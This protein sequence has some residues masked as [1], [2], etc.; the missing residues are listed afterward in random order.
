MQNDS[1]PPKPKHTA[2]FSRDK[3]TEI[4]LHDKTSSAADQ[5]GK[6]PI[7]N[8]ESQTSSTPRSIV[9]AAQHEKP[10]KPRNQAKC[11][12]GLDSKQSRWKNIKKMLLF[13]PRQR[14]RNRRARAEASKSQAVDKAQSGA[15]QPKIHSSSSNQAVPM[16]EKSMKETTKPQESKKQETSDCHFIEQTSPSQKIGPSS[17]FVGVA[18][19]KKVVSN[20]GT[21]PLRRNKA[22]QI[23]PNV[24]KG[25]DAAKQSRGMDEGQLDLSLVPE[26]DRSKN[27]EQLHET[28]EP[29]SE[30][31]CPRTR[32]L[33]N[34]K[35]RIHV[36]SL[37]SG[38]DVRQQKGNRQPNV[39]GMTGLT[40]N[41]ISVPFI[42]A[43]D[44]LSL[45]AEKDQ[46]QSLRDPRPRADCG[47]D[48]HASQSA[49]R[50]PKYVSLRSWGNSRKRATEESDDLDS[51][52]GVK[53]EVS[54]G[55]ESMSRQLSRSFFDSVDNALLHVS[56]IVTAINQGFKPKRQAG[57]DSELSDSQEGAVGRS[58]E[59]GGKM[60][61]ETIEMLRD[62]FVEYTTRTR[63]S[64]TKT[65]ASML[66]R[67]SAIL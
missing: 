32:R 15:S 4:E 28:E 48:N 44:Q 60:E 14:R 36:P 51:P 33:Q 25:Q 16:T 41:A 63:Q 21:F 37:R 57:R 46:T 50:S 5:S 7:N 9:T 66:G 47:H 56:D 61:G 27:D 10:D 40:R 67:K 18:F 52:W 12:E 17:E 3:P 13:S 58:A 22:P 29:I 59:E 35:Q 42:T 30:M 39:A 53:G 43:A 23:S 26:R 24:N 55:S 62:A 49:V 65:F 11:M 6:I 2:P 54:S 34:F 19:P 8:D 31:K 38:R 64:S 45:D 1:G 20:R